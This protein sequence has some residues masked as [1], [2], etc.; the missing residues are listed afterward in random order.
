MISR[1]K[2]YVLF[3]LLFHQVIFLAQESNFIVSDMEI[4]NKKFISNNFFI[5]GEMHY[6]SEATKLVQ[7]QLVREILERGVKRLNIYFELPP[8]SIFFIE[9]YYLS[10]KSDNIKK[11]F[12]ASYF[13][14]FV[15]DLRQYKNRVEIRFIGV[16]VEF[17]A[18]FTEVKLFFTEA[19]KGVSYLS[20][21]RINKIKR[22]KKF[23]KIID[24]IY[25]N[26]NSFY[27]KYKNEI[28]SSSLQA[29]YEEVKVLSEYGFIRGGRRGV[30]KKKR[31][32]YLADKIEK[33]YNDSIS[34]ILTIGRA[35]ISSEDGSIPDFMLEMD[36][37]ERNNFILIPIIYP[38]FFWIKYNDFI[39]MEYSDFKMLVD[40]NVFDVIFLIEEE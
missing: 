38:S 32:M 25:K 12:L 19:L 4:I 31:N 34:H 27:D 36:N 8:S 20:S 33:E 2:I 14:P 16:D 39:Y 3:I 6:K 28:D 17:R 11:D 13:I 21:K 9:N 35:H 18:H 10:K 29:L 5:L 22:K 40:K 15:D 23:I 37:L 7:N 24:E 1:V 26:Y 30:S